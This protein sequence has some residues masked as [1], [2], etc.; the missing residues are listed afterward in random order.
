[1]VDSRLVVLLRLDAKCNRNQLWTD[2][3]MHCIWSVMIFAFAANT[4]Y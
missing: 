4:T 2:F 1:M 3:G